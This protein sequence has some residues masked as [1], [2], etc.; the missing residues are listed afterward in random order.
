MVYATLGLKLLRKV[1]QFAAGVRRGTF[2]GGGHNRE[3]T[4]VAA[5][6]VLYPIIYIALT[7]PLSIGRMWSMARDGRSYSNAYAIFAGCMITSCG[8][9]DALVYSL[10]RLRLLQATGMAVDRHRCLGSG[11]VALQSGTESSA[12]VPELAVDS[13]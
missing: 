6:L 13:T 3:I 12:K 1:Q 2:V 8:F 11:E 5:L 10:T 4:R 9:A 7:L